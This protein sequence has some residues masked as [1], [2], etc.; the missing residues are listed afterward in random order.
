MLFLTSAVVSSGE[1]DED[2]CF[3]APKIYEPIESMDQL[4]G[5][6]QMFMAQYNEAVRGAGMD[7]VF[8]TV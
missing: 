8:F 5:R 6:L 1:E 3:D 4:R 2:A 7:L